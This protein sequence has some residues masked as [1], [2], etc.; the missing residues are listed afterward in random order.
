MSRWFRHYAGMMRDE[1]L[2]RVAVK[3]KQP[4][5]RV[6]WAWGAILESAA[7][8]NDAGRYEFDV[9]EAAYFLRCDETDLVDIIA[10][11]IHLGRL[12]DG[13]VARWSERQFDSDSAKERQRR[14]RERVSARNTIQQRNGDV[15]E[16]TKTVTRD[17]TQPSRDG[18]LTLQETEAE[19]EKET[20]PSGVVCAAL[21]AGDLPGLR[22]KLID[23]VGESNIQGHGT[24]DLSAVLGLIE[25]G[26]DLETDILPT[27]RAKAL[28]LKHPAG[29]WGYFT[30]SIREAYSRRIEA[31]KGLIAPKPFDDSDERWI[32]RL[33]LSRERRQ[34][35][36]AEY[37]P[38]PGQPGCRV[39]R[40]LLEPSDGVGWKVWD[41]AA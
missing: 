40:H 30:N 33:K 28:R 38:A 10:G 39:P 31:G 37:G 16:A 17:V 32:K 24:Q 26:V 35:S 9:G 25:A 12:V 29:S 13:V 41:E 4:V 36:F 27:I 21:P 14:Y 15:A 3:A 22:A 2:V 11:L 20:T 34:W 19:T 23:A 7:E 6:V 1:K 18:A 8:I 5:E